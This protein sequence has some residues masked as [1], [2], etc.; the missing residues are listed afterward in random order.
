MVCGVRRATWRSQVLGVV[1]I[2]CTVAVLA[3]GCSPAGSPTPEPTSEPAPSSLTTEPTSSDEPVEPSSGSEREPLAPGADLA[4]ADLV[5]GLVTPWDVEPLDGGSALVSSRDTGEIVLMG[6]GG[7]VDVVGTVEQT[8]PGGEGG[9]LGLALSE[10][11]GTLFAY[12]TTAE[13]N[14]VVAMAWDGDALGEPTVILDGIPRAANHNGGGLV[15]GPDGYLYVSTGD[16]AEPGNAQDL[17]SLGGKILRIDARGEPAPDNPFG[18][19]VYSYGHRNVQGLAFDADGRLWATEFGQNTWDE[20]NLIEPGGNYGWPEVEGQG[21]GDGVIDP[22]QIWA[23]SEA[24]PSGLAYWRG[25][26]WMAGLRG[27]TLWQIPL[28]GASTSDPV[29]HLAGEHGRL[30]AAVVTADG[31][32]LLVGTSNTDGRGDVRDGDDRLLILTG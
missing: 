4:V 32:A 7:A 12:V 22:L 18:T 25:S 16:A 15:V 2:S 24:S 29:A 5:V 1:A 30:R 21:G 11:G 19:A 3:T 17:G 9:L 27:E 6:S 31:D 14:R 8:A 10:D 28:D 23:T 20:L 26:L 13:D